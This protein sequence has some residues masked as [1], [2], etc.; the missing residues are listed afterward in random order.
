MVGGGMTD[1]EE[2]E[3]RAALSRWIQVWILRIALFVGAVAAL[4]FS[5]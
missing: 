3:T 4:V 5:R 2:A 1:E